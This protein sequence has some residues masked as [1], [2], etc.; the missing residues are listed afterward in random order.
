MLATTHGIPPDWIKT[1]LGHITLAVGTG[2]VRSL[3]VGGW[4]A[5]QGYE[6]PHAVAPGLVDAW[7]QARGLS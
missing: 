3:A 7:K 4:Y 2:R 1:A 6:H 5:F